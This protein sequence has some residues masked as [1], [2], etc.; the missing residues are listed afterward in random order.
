MK[1]NRSALIVILLLVTVII[2][3][4][5]MFT[6]QADYGVNWQATFYNKTDLDHSGAVLDAMFRFIDDSP[7]SAVGVQQVRKNLLDGR[8]TLPRLHVSR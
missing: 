8:A 2:A 7:V 1:R 4:V 3:T 5:P 6:V